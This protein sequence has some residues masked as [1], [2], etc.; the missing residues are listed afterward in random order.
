MDRCGTLSARKFSPLT[1][2]GALT[3]EKNKDIKL[4]ASIENALKVN[5]KVKELAIS[6]PELGSYLT[7]LSKNLDDA[8]NSIFEVYG[9]LELL[10][11]KL[12]IGSNYKDDMTNEADSVRA[13]LKILTVSMEKVSDTADLMSYATFKEN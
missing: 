7:Q 13:V 11:N 3:M 12:S 8:T 4:N 10:E 6:E 9:I 1:K 2:K 5:P